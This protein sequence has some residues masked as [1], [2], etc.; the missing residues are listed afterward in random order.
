MVIATN[1]E[2]PAATTE[3]LRCFRIGCIFLFQQIHGDLHAS[4]GRPYGMQI[5]LK[6]L[7]NQIPL[8]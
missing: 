4:C 5:S 8:V 2:I 6:Q 7:F 1:P 3:N